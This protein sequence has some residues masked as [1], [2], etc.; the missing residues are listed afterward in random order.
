[1]LKS[2]KNVCSC[3]NLPEHLEKRNEWAIDNHHNSLVAYYETDCSEKNWNSIHIAAGRGRHANFMHEYRRTNSVSNTTHK[4]Q[5]FGPDPSSPYF[6]ISCN[7]SLVTTENWNYVATENAIN[8][9][10]TTAKIADDDTDVFVDGLVQPTTNK[11]ELAT[12]VEP[13]KEK[14]GNLYTIFES[15]LEQQGEFIKKLD[16]KITDKQEEIDQTIHNVSEK[17][18]KIENFQVVV[19][20]EI[21]NQ[22]EQI[23]E[24]VSK[25]HEFFAELF[26]NK[27]VTDFIRQM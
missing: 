11:V 22:N 12:R 1:M 19:N 27:N 23:V 6:R 5:S 16:E 18:R 7:V 4:I 2:Y 25:I 8:Y 10:S 21:K 20:E 15:F 24:V 26:F 9:D 13:S 14:Q 3:I 17:V